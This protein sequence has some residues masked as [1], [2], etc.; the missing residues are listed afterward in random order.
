MSTIEQKGIAPSWTWGSSARVTS[1]DNTM[2]PSVQLAAVNLP[3]PAVCSL[4]FQ[5]QIV[6]PSTDVLAAV[7]AFSLFMLQG[8]GRVTVPRTITFDSQPAIDSPLEFT[9]PFVPLHAL[10][11]NVQQ[12]CHDIATSPLTTEVYLVMSPITRIAAE[13]GKDPMVFGM[14]LPGEADSMDHELV[15]ELE[16]EAPSVAAIMAADAEGRVLEEPEE[17]EVVTV[18]DQQ[19]EAIANH[20]ATRL[21]REPTDQEILTAYERLQRRRRRRAWRR[22][23]Q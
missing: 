1:V 7:G 15:A 14:S 18:E 5:V 3:E 22:R 19:I 21:G 17:P 12:I 16:A 10:Q 2:T 9:L 20:L 6:V 13:K 8:V 4:Y 11:V 23:G